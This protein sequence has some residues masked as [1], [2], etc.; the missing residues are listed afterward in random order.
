MPTFAFKCFQVEKAALQIGNYPLAMRDLSDHFSHPLASLVQKIVVLNYCLQFVF[1]G[2]LCTLFVAYLLFTR[3]YLLSL[4]YLAWYIY[5]FKTGYQGMLDGRL[6]ETNLCQ[7]YISAG[8][9]R[10]ELIRHAFTA[11][12][13]AR[14][15]PIEL[16]K[17][18]DLPADRNYIFGCHPHGILSISHFANFATE[19]THFSAI[20]PNLR[21]HMMAMNIL[22]W[23]PLHREYVLSSGKRYYASW[24]ATLIIFL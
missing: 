7:W 8:G 5:D 15:F 12:Y 21:P 23:M 18:V 3:F 14:Y 16:I 11:R 24:L 4:L 6:Q 19:G 10:S 20:F 13:F 2:P 9:R 22:F 17:T 1:V